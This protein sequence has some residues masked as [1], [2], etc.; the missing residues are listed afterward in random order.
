MI[1]LFKDSANTVDLTLTELSV[2]GDYN[3]LL[4]FQNKETRQFSYCFL[5][6]DFSNNTQR[7]NEFIITEQESPNP[8]LSQ[9][10]LSV[11][12]YYYN[13]Y[14]LT[15]QQ[16]SD[17]DFDNIDVT[18]YNLVEGSGKMRMRQDR[19]INTYYQDAPLTNTIYE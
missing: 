7:S 6:S 19:E 13:A 3:Y 12:E 5:G 14:Q 16:V 10:S 11:G 4:Q 9:V 8:L 18:Q 15:N 1:S 17:L 2:V